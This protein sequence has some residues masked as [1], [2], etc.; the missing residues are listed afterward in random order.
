M[1]ILKNADP[2]L[3]AQEFR[4]GY[5]INGYEF[6]KLTGE[7]EN[8]EPVTGT[9]VYSPDGDPISSLKPV[10]TELCKLLGYRQYCY[11]KKGAL[12]VPLDPSYKT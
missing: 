1:L 5:T 7:D 8:G 2:T 4:E 11:P 9:A 3:P 6:R 10:D 12:A